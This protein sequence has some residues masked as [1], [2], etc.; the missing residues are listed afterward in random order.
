MRLGVMQQAPT[1][2]EAQGLANDVIQ[3]L[4]A[5]V[6]KLGIPEKNIQT[7][8]MSLNPIY[9]QPRP[10]EAIKAS[11]SGGRG[12]GPTRLMVPERTWKSW[13]SSSSEVA[14]M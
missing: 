4:I 7:A 14:R 6:A 11:S 8:R 2:Q 13:G 5:A 9:N 3:K 10:G 1:A 12:R